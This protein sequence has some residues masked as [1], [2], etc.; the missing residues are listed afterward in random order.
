MYRVNIL[1]SKEKGKTWGKNDTDNLIFWM[2][3]SCMLNRWKWYTASFQGFYYGIK[4]FLFERM[5]SFWALLTQDTFNA[6]FDCLKNGKNSW[7]ENSAM[8]EWLLCFK[9][10][11]SQLWQMISCS[12]QLQFRKIYFRIN[13]LIFTF[14]LYSI[15]NQTC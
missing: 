3:I 13:L 10:S 7:N 11:D 14:Q 1:N 8:L 15:Q 5:S 6:D 2:M 12:F 9:C 4:L